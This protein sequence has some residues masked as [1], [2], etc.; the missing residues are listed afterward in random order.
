LRVVEV[1]RRR[2]LEDVAV[3]STV[4][5][6]V[7]A[8]VI[9]KPSYGYEIAERYGRRF[10]FFLPAGRSAVYGALDRLEGEALVQPRPPEP[11]RTGGHRRMY[12]GY[13][14]TSEAIPTHR[15]W[16]SSPIIT[17]RWRNEL[18]ARIGTAH[19]H[20]IPATLDQ[21]DRYAWH[22]Q[23]H[24]QHI[25]QLIADR[26]AGGQRSLLARSTILLLREQQKTTATHIDWARYARGEIKELTDGR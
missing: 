21:L 2:P 26:T 7:L 10:D 17:E 14:P 13:D 23:A 18:L 25:Q 11:G 12:V 22:A 6:L 3:V 16:L 1:P 19:L 15:R 4:Y 8:L 9:E 24:Q 5:W 20:G